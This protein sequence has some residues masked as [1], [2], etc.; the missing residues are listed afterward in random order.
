MATIA[1]GLWTLAI[2]ALSIHGEE[3]LQMTDTVTLSMVKGRFDHFALEAAGERLFV[4]ALGNNSVEVLDVKSK[5]RVTSI[6]R[7]RK[8]LGIVLLPESKRAL[9]GAPIKNRDPGR[10]ADL[11]LFKR[12]G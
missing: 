4:A 8:S 10:R 12:P 1:L 9:D 3:A 2:I 5:R 6:Q 7:V 11:I